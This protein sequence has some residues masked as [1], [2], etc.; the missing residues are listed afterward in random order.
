M[1]QYLRLIRETQPTD[2]T[3]IGLQQL[4]TCLAAA[5]GVETIKTVELHPK[6]GFSVT[7]ESSGDPCYPVIEHLLSHGYRPA[8]P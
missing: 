4:Q 1:H 3:S 7:F 6:G 8:F 5:P 2:Y